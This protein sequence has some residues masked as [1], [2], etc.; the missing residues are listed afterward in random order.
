MQN[1]AQQIALI[2]ALRAQHARG[3]NGY[4][5]DQVGG[6]SPG[7]GGFGG[8]DILGGGPGAVGAAGL[9][10]IVGL[11]NPAQGRAL[12]AN[13]LANAQAF[14]PAQ[15]M[16]A[17]QLLQQPVGLPPGAVWGADVPRV[18]RKQ[19]IALG[20]RITL[21]AGLSATITATPQS[22]ARIE[23]LIIE[24]IGTA[25]ASGKDFVVSRLDIG[26]MRQISGAGDLPGTM[27]EAGGF[28]LDSKLDTSNPGNQVIITVTNVTV[29][30]IT[31]A[32]GAVGTVVR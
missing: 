12:M 29:A 31:L 3:V 10:D 6:V 20:D 7:Y 17:A 1:L 21:G 25:T 4:G 5:A 11:A 26:D 8:F 19:Y 14:N 13:A 16:D 30:A 23:R 28:Q 27:F 18:A 9:L 32:A 24:S 22:V 2:N 15:V